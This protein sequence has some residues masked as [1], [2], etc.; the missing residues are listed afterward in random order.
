MSLGWDLSPTAFLGG[1]ESLGW[2]HSEALGRK[3]ERKEEHR[4]KE[5]G[6]P[7]PT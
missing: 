6:T 2:D 4:S 5:E 7:S 1:V 3:V